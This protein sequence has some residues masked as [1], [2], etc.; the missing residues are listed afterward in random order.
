[1][2]VA[3]DTSRGY[4]L[5][6][7]ASALFVLNAGV[8]R[9]IQAAGVGSMLLTSV[10]CTG[11]AIVLLAALAVRGERLSLPRTWRELAVVM[12]FGVT[13][14]AL[15]QYFYFV[16]I[17]RLP[18]GIALLLEFTAPVLVALFARFVYREHVRSRMWLGIGC[19]L[20]GLALVAEVWDGLT[21]DTL[22]ALAGIAAAVSLATYFLIGEHSVSVDPPLHVLTK[23]FIVA[24]ILWN[25]FAPVT[26]LWDAGLASSRSLGGQLANLHAPLW[27]L[28]TW[29]IVLG[30]VV[31]FFTELSALRYLTATEVTLVGMLEPV[32]ATILGWL[33]FDES[34]G[35]LQIVGVAVVLTGIGL[36][37]TAR[38][39]SP[40][41]GQQ[42]PVQ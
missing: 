17:D 24:A 7:T 9:V 35:A 29:L 22:G 32:G 27:L 31:P 38:P 8:S 3:E 18:V 20:A 21:L 12:G 1:M 33:W 6:L 30:T 26:D 25:A 39:P 2:P 10:R 4:A 5:V 28:V 42:V 40:A 36:A 41:A 13:G 14:V 15:V 19:S 37:Q 23:A 34:L 11:T 16:A